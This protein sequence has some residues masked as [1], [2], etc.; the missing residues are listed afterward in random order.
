MDQLTVNFISRVAILIKEH[1]KYELMAAAAEPYSDE[2]LLKGLIQSMM[3]AYREGLTP[4]QAA[5]IVVEGMLTAAK[6]K[7]HNV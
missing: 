4:L 3:I 2:A 5:D 7:E 6:Q 1:P